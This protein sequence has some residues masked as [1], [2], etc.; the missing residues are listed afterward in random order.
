M[1]ETETV[2][3]VEALAISI[4]GLIEVH[5]QDRKDRREYDRTTK[6][7]LAS[8]E[9]CIVEIKMSTGKMEILHDNFVISNAEKASVCDKIHQ[10]VELRLRAIPTSRCTQ[11]EEQLKEHDDQFKEINPL[12]YKMAAGATVVAGVVSLVVPYLLKKVG[13]P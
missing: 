12:V 1:G 9:K 11:H 13:G 6:K 2:A 7:T 3:M 5:I 4:Q 8:I 10:D